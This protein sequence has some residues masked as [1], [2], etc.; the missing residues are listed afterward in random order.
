MPGIFRRFSKRDKK[1]KSSGDRL[2]AAMEKRALLNAKDVSPEVLRDYGNLCLEAG[3]TSDAF[4]FY[5]AAKDP[6]GLDRIKQLAIKE[7]LAYLLHW[8]EG[9]AGHP[10]SRQEWIDAAQ[11]ARRLG[12]SSFA[13]LA[14]EKAG[15]SSPDSEEPSS[16]SGDQQPDTTSD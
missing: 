1:L 3:R 10:V 8:L 16:T 4:E 12:K 7:G 2:P 6:D 13:R 5:A 9:R 15:I 14:E 11:N